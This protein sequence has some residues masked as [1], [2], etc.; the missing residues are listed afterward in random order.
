VAGIL[1][2]IMV[3]CAI[4]NIR[5]WLQKLER[6]RKDY[7]KACDQLA[8]YYQ[9]TELLA[10]ELAKA[11]SQDRNL[12]ISSNKKKVE[13]AGLSRPVWT[14]QRPVNPSSETAEL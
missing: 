2:G 7:R 8:S 12:I 4:S 10:T 3:P 6:I 13:Q 11:T 14:P 1:I 9:M 5:S